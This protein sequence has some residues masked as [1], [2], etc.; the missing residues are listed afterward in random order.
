MNA[1]HAAARG[2]KSEVTVPHRNKNEVSVCQPYTVSMWVWMG[3][4]LIFWRSCK[5]TQE[6]IKIGQ[7]RQTRRFEKRMIEIGLTLSHTLGIV[8]HALR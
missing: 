1:L 8:N 5:E 2:T 6:A 7:S 4:C 3:L